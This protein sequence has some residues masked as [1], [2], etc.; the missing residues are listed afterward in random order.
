MNALPTGTVTFLFTD[1]EGSTRLLEARPEAYRRNLARHDAIVRQAVASHG[2]VI[3]QA[4][5]DG[6]CAAFA[7]PTEAARAALDGQLA[8]RDEPWVEVGQVQVR[9]GL[10][11]GEVELHGDEYFGVPLHRC[12]RLMDS[13]HGGQV[14]LSAVTAALIGE[15]L[16][17]GAWLKDLGEHRLRDLVRTDRVYQLVGPDLLADFPP[18]RTLTA[19]PNNLP[20]QATAF[21]G[22]EQQLQAVRTSLQRSDARLVTL[23]GPGGTGKTRLALQA[24]ADLLDS[25]PDGVFFVALASVTDPDL[26]ASAIAQALDVREAAGRPITTS[27]ADALRQKHLLLLLDNFEQVVAAAPV[28]A[29]LLSAAPRTKMLVTSRS[30]LR[31]YGERELSVPPL[32]LPDRRTSPSVTHLAQFEGSR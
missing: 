29:E 18:L 26:V 14:P 28:V 5:G 31:V 15:T 17:S 12:S 20:M 30:V 4:R 24:A 2:G 32:A 3:V 11:T 19:I 9:M 22:R 10:H 6:F 23:T 7:S 25:F 27:L 16:P 13:A 1:I 8:L 21:I